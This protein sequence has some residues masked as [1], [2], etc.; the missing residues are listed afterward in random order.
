M[1]A[2]QFV[3]NTVIVAGIALLIIIGICL[4]LAF[5][6]SLILGVLL[7]IPVAVVLFLTGFFGGK[8]TIVGSTICLC[9]FCALIF[10]AEHTHIHFT[11]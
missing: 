5:S 11:F 4:N 10:I 2:L 1:Y 6:A 9:C 7:L 8:K 3:R